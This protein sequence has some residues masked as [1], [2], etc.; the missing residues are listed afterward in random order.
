MLSRI[1]LG[2]GVMDQAGLEDHSQ[3]VLLRRPARA[4]G[5]PRSRTGTRLVDARTKSFPE[6]RCVVFCSLSALS[7]KES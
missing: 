5:A 6:S 1:C 7:L 2:R 4:G 3:S